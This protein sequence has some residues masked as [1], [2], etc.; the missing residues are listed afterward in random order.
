MSYSLTLREEAEADIS[1]QFTYYEEVRLGLGHDF[2]LCLEE[3]FSQTQ[4]NP[5]NYRTIYKHL[6]RKPGLFE[7]RLASS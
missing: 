3:A 4:R 1:K 7:L 2:F 5:E 6:R